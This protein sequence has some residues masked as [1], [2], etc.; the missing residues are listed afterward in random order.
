M[1][2]TG[3]QELK[4]D[5]QTLACVFSNVGIYD[6]GSFK[7]NHCL[8]PLSTDLFESFIHSLALFIHRKQ[9]NDLLRDDFVPLSYMPTYENKVSTTCC[10]KTDWMNPFSPV[11]SLIFGIISFTTN[12]EGAKIA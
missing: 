1:I 7:A 11:A 4:N 12:Y 10:L 3:A 6:N 5:P 2:E 8:K 9:A